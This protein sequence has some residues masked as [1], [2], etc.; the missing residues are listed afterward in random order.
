MK[1]NWKSSPTWAT[2]WLE[3]EGNRELW[4]DKEY[5][6]GIKIGWVDPLPLLSVPEVEDAGDFFMLRVLQCI[7]RP[8]WKTLIHFKDSRKLV[9]YEAEGHLSHSAVKRQ[10]ISELGVDSGFRFMLEYV[11]LN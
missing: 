10:L 4:S 5:T 2:H 8:L 7:P 3:L 9:T 1:P 11:K 6:N